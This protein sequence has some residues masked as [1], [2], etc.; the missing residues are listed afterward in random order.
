[1]KKPIKVVAAMLAATMALSMAACGKDSKE[2]EKKWTAPSG[3][4]ETT[5][6]TTAEETT[7]AETTAAADGSDA[8]G[9][10]ANADGNANSGSLQLKNLKGAVPEPNCKI[11]FKKQEDRYH[12]NMDLTLDTENNTIGGHVELTFFN[13]SDKDW[14]KLCL[15]DYSSLFINAQTAGYDGALDTNG[16]LTKIENITDGRSNET[17]KLDRETDVSVVWLSLSK[18]LAPGEKMTLSYDFEAKIPTVAD[19]YG[20]DDGVFN[21]TNFYPILAEYTKDGWSHEKYYGCG[22]CFF[23]EIS[24]YDVKI[25]TKD[26]MVLLT[27]GL[28]NGEEKKDG[29]KTQS[30]HADCVRDFVFCASSKFKLVEGDYKDTHIRVAYTEDDL[31]EANKMLA[32]ESLRAAVDSLSAFGAAFGE[33]PYKDLEVIIT[34]ISAGGM[35]Y[36]NLVIIT[37]NVDK[38]TAAD[39]ASFKELCKN[40]ADYIVSHE[41]GHQWFMGIIGSNSGMQP[42][43]DES[44]ASYT[45]IVYD[46]YVYPDSGRY[47]P[48][49]DEELEAARKATEDFIKQQEG[50]GDD[51]VAPV[52]AFHSMFF[53]ETT[54]K[55]LKAQGLT[56]VNRAYYAYPDD[57]TYVESVYQI[58]KEA[59]FNIG[60]TLGRDEFY[61]IIREYIQRNAFT[62]ADQS[63]FFEVLYELA[64]TDNEQLNEMMAAYFDENGQPQK[65]S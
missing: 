63:D 45:E 24:D 4:G 12:Y 38:E 30:F 13:D 65:V 59:I 61:G 64:G 20:V 5:V 37:K 39:T 54:A 46:L 47:T 56:P 52:F 49:T 53:N 16:A 34:P 40:T 31:P 62:N 51:A 2:T 27:T 26:D 58:G 29:M 6:A 55:F 3:T 35:E 15:R 19:R 36:P 22:E 23:S 14:E 10:D 21:I 57:F 18:A 50:G 17:L 44:F 28:E 48:P 41:I 7:T 33:Y 8:S 32:D 43:L 42:W 1:M 11:E 9:A 25:T 60:E